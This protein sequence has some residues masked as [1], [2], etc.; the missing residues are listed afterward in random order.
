MNG[1]SEGDEGGNPMEEKVTDTSS[2]QAR[3]KAVGEINKRLRQRM[4]EE[5]KKK[6]IRE[7]AE[8]ALTRGGSQK[9][10][11]AYWQGVIRNREETKQATTAEIAAVAAEK[12]RL[13]EAQ[14][15]REATVVR[16]E[17]V[18]DTTRLKATA[19]AR[20]RQEMPA[21]NDQEDK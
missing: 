2:T 5:E 20:D 13:A 12:A 21:V 16:R 19:A 3:R 17:R 11:E 14:R 18:I 1:T 4:A 9:A 10:R 8:A 7:T 6:K 15:K